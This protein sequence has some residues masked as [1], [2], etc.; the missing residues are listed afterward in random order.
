MLRE[1]NDGILERTLVVGITAT[2]ILFAFV[3]T[4]FLIILIHTGLVLTV[5]FVVFNL[6][7]H[8]EILWI[9]LLIVMTGKK[10]FFKFFFM[11]TD[12]KN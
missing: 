9:A 12:K 4:E 10:I 3:G 8:G 7:I 1:R 5:A 2:E 11:I 6:T